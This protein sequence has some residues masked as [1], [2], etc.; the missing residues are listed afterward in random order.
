MKICLLLSAV[1][2]ILMG[3]G[4]SYLGERYILIRLF[5]RGNLPTLSGGTWYTQQILRFAWHLTSILFWGFAAILA[6]MAWEAL[7][8]QNIATV[9]AATFFL[10]GLLT[11]IA[12]K[13]KHLAWLVFWLVA[14]VCLI[15]VAG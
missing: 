8:F 6:L 10:C 12:T 5:K 2:F 3:V 15:G 11:L 13:G 14:G 1:L 4:H 7:Q 9:L